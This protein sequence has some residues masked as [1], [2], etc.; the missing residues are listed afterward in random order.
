MTTGKD[1]G[2]WT[3]RQIL[4]ALLSTAASGALAN[5]PVSSPRPQARRQAGN[6]DHAAGNVDLHALSGLS[7]KCGYVVADADTGE[8]LESLNPLLGLPPAST[9]KA[10]TTI[11]GLT[12]LGSEYRFVTRVLAT[13]PVENGELKGDLVLAGGGDP[14]L[15]TDA[16]ASLAKQLKDKGVRRISGGALVWSGA[17]PY[18]RQIDADQ[19]DHLGYNPSL[20]GLNLNYNR[21]YFEWKRGTGG[22]EVTMD[23]RTRKYRPMVAMTTIKVVER[24]SPIYTQVST[25]DMDQWTVARRALG[26]KGG[27]WLPVRRPE[28]YAAEVFHTIARSYGIELPRFRKTDQPP[29]GPIMA[30]WCSEPLPGLLRDMLMYSTNLV[31]EAVGMSASQASGKSPENLAASGRMMSDW[32]KATGNANHAK[33]VDHSGLGED[34]RISARDMVRVLNAQGWNGALHGL[35]K[36]IWLRDDKG[37]PIKAHPVKVQAKTGTLNFVSALAGYATGPNGRHLAFAIFTA[38]LD[39]RKKIGKSQRERPV[40]ARGW[41]RQSKILQQKLIERWSDIYRA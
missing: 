11:Y 27:R 35:M 20:S 15:D 30:E 12:M 39:K 8:V 37:R 5:A 2:G 17:L 23:A 31:A 16:L 26:K 9:A 22:F 10:L 25:K 33:F 29:N 19:P 4:A 36:E 6:G 34:S 7:G 21:I 28:Y 38:D 1:F 32:L 24:D 40:G 3:R 13:G 18:Q 41:N 14:T